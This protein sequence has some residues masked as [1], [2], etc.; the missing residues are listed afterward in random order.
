MNIYHLNSNQQLL[1]SYLKCFSMIVIKPI[2]LLATKTLF[3]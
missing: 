2:N 1:N 3:E